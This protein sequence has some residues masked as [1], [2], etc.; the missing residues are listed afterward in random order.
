MSV[1]FGL[2]FGAVSALAWG[3]TDICGTVASRRAGSIAVS[4]WMQIVAFVAMLTLTLLTRATLPEIGELAS[5][6]G[7]GVVAAIGY[8]AVYEALRRG[9]IS[10]TSPV[11]SAYGGLTVLLAVVLLGESLTAPQATGVG[12]ATGGLILAVVTLRPSGN[13]TAISGPGVPFAL[14]AIVAWSVV[15]IVQAPVIRTTGWI[16][17]ITVVRGVAAFVLGAALTGQLI[18]W[19]LRPGPALRVRRRLDAG[20]AALVLGM[21]ACDT[22]GYAAFG[23]GIERSYT[24]VVGLVASLG[25]IGTVIFGVAVLGERPARVQWAGMGLVLVGLALIGSQ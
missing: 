20:T 13:R 12:L 6:V 9:P 7:A 16:P 19:R 1:G 5:L 10:I 11:V 8:V 15:T 3:L 14:V 21:A 2:A 24:W 17:A 25:P 23:V 22:I 18:R 4:A